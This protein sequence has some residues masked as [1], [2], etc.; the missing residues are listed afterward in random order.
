MALLV[1]LLFF[2][3]ILDINSQYV[4]QPRLFVSPEVLT[5]SGSVYLHCDV[6]HSVKVS[7]CYFYPERDD[8]NIKLSPSCQL[9]VTGSELIRWTGRSSPGTLHI[10]CYYTVDKSWIQAPSPHSLPAPVTVLNQKPVLS[11]AHDDQFDEFRL[12]CEIPESE[13]VRADF[14]CNLYT[15]ENPQPY[16]TQTSQK[17]QSGNLVC[18]FKAERND[19]F[20]RLQSVKSDEVSCDY[21]L[22]SDPTARS[23]MSDKYNMIHFFPEPT[24][25]P[26]TN[27]PTTAK[28]VTQNHPH[29]SASAPN[30]ERVTRNH[31][32]SSA[33]APNTER[34]TRNH[35]HSSASAPNTERVTRNHPHSPT[36]A[37]NKLSTV[38]LLHISTKGEKHNTTKQP[39]FSKS[40]VLVL[41]L[42]VT[43]VCVL[44]A[45]LMIVCLC[46]FIKKQAAARCKMDLPHGDQGA[47]VSKVSENT[48][49]A[50]TVVTYT[51]I[52]SVPLPS[53][54]LD[55]GGNNKDFKET[56]D[57][58]YHMYC[59]IADT[60]VN[61]KG[62]DAAYSLLQSTTHRM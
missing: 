49:P 50:D 41:L 29:S 22:I 15:G 59:T 58:V 24:Q 19:L 5:V 4:P 35:P 28:R 3:L 21:S 61:A 17:R 39:V 31:P 40:S 55:S 54:S 6:P 12:V 51:V 10:I 53:Q 26:T 13:S 20:R 37:P 1:L 36:S 38:S 62:T 33:S 45:G 52:S 18:I 16:R 43:G 27:R 14:S 60:Q 56:G 46:R 2:H 32:H 8:T 25:P 42:S 7:Q 47:M 11:V 44:L 23:L 34:V 48:F 57:D 9:S 30:T